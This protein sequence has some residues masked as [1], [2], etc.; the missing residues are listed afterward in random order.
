MFFCPLQP[1]DAHNLM[2]PETVESLFYMYRFTGDKMY[3]DWGWTIFQA[4]LKHSKVTDGFTSLH[5]V[6]S[7][8]NPGYADK[9]ESFFLSE[10]LK[11][12]YL[13]FNDD[14]TLIP[15]DKYVFNTE[16]HPL[17]IYSS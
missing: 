6:K 3:Q 9:L 12:L 10:T 7:A 17:P 5:N 16:G 8:T 2:R 4:F 11:Y 13:L 15:L 14:N 1:A